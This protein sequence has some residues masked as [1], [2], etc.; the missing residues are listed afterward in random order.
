M[1]K[2]SLILECNVFDLCKEH[3]AAQRA[4]WQQRKLERECRRQKQLQ[5]RELEL[6]EANEALVKRLRKL[7]IPKAQPLPRYLSQPL[8]SSHSNSSNGSIATE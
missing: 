1:Y 5:Q 8:Q 6:R 4:E 7:M 3:R 2:C